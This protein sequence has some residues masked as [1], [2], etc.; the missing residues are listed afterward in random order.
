MHRNLFV[1]LPSG[2]AHPPLA[3]GVGL[4]ARQVLSTDHLNPRLSCHTDTPTFRVNLAQKRQGKS[5]F[6]RCLAT[7][8]LVKWAEISS[9]LGTLGDGFDIF[10]LFRLYLVSRS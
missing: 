10:H 9:P 7:N 8:V 3:H 5:I 2:M 1:T 4:G 6:T